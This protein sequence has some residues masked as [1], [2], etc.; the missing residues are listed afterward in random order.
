M[1]A[2]LSLPQRE[3]WTVDDLAE[4]PPDLPYEL[5]N[6][7]LVLMSPDFVHETVCFRVM[8]ALDVKCPVGYRPVWDFSL[9]VG[10]Y[11]QPRPDVVVMDTSH[12]DQHPP[13]VEDAVLAIEVVS[14]DSRFRDFSEKAGMYAGAGVGKYWVIDPLADK[15]SLTE[16]VLDRQR[17]R[18]VL[19]GVT[20][21]VFTTD[22]PYP[23]TI[24]LPALTAERDAFPGRSKPAE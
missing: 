22:L 15:I 7:R 19:D 10:R 17:R 21:D 2:A 24:D 9:N 4:L 1:T 6:G 13:P 8:Q 20:T 16:M 14:K 12:V 18:Y 11:D 5:V 3:V 23:I